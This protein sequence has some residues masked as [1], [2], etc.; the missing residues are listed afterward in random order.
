MSECISSAEQATTHNKPT[1]ILATVVPENQRMAFLPKHFGK[2]M[3]HAESAVY[4]AMMRLCRTYEGGY[5][6]FIELSNGGCYL[7][8]DTPGPLGVRVDGN[9]FSGEMSVDAASILATLFALN[10]L[11][12]ERNDA[13]FT[14]QYYLLFD[15]ALQHDE[16][17]KILRAID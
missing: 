3:L 17:R 5:W 8:L 16:K 10:A 7:R 2:D 6:N 1:G 9:G 12:W 11:S 4:E 14:D 15:Y 13:A